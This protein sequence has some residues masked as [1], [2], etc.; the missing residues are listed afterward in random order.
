[1]SGSL[2]IKKPTV[3]ELAGIAAADKA[4]NSRELKI[5]VPELLPFLKGN[6]EATEVND[7]V[8]TSGSKDSYSGS[9]KTKNYIVASYRG[10]NSNRSFPPDIRKGEQVI[11]T[12]MGD[13]D[14][15]W[16]RESAR[17]DAN[18]RT[19][20][21][22]FSISGTTQTQP[23]THDDNSY[24]IEIDTRRS[25]RI[26]MVTSKADGEKYKYVI[27]IDADAGKIFIGDDDKNLITLE[28]ENQRISMKNKEDSIIEMHGKDITIACKGDICIHSQEGNIKMHAKEKIDIR[29]DNGYYAEAGEGEVS[30]GMGPGGEYVVDSSADHTVACKGKLTQSG[31]KGIE[32]NSGAD[33]IQ[34]ITGSWNMGF[35]GTGVCQA[36][37]TMTM[38]VQQLNIVGN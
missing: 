35:G 13:S 30:V 24:F 1:M 8:N 16:W 34:K 14:K 7:S 4:Q 31:S 26:R 36:D 12:N 11:V 32:E 25:H 37:G 3:I 22:R 18:R 19:E 2:G 15:W 20:T 23:M 5:Y 27:E 6:L 29:A 38:Q 33:L 21:L 17:N 10:N 9:I 28:S